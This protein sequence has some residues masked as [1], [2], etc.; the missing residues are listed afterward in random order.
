MANDETRTTRQATRRSCHLSICASFVIRHSSF[1]ILVSNRR[2]NSFAQ[3]Q[4]RSSDEFCSGT[5]NYSG[6][7]G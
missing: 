3:S 6:R 2:P 7:M 5:S 1:V 4:L